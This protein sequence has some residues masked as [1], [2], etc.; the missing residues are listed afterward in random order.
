MAHSYT[1]GLKV[2][3]N[4]KILKE[5]RL[6]LK[7]SVDTSVGD[8]VAPGDTIAKTDLPGNVQMVNIANQLN[9]DA[10][11]VETVMIAKEGSKVS[12]NDLIAQTNGIFG[13]FKSSVNSPVDGTIESVSNITGQVVI[14]EAP[15][16]VEVDA[17]IRGVVDE[18]ITEEGVVIKSYGSF[19]QG[20]FGIGGESR[21]EIKMLSENRTSEISV[22]MIKPEHEGLIIVGGSF[23]SLEAYKK[24]LE[25]KV[26]GV[27]VGGFNYYDLEE[28]LGYTLGV[29]ITGS[30]ELIT[31]LIVT[32][33]YGKI[34]M[35]QQTFDLLRENSGRLAS[36][37]GATQIRAGVIRPEIIIP[38]DASSQ[39]DSDENSKK[40]SGMTEG[41]L[42]RVIRSPNFGKIGSVKELPSELRKMESETMVRVAII[43]IDGELI[44][45]PRSNLEVVETD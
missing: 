42:V 15:I 34:Q 17:Y 19:V 29:A 13:Y 25:C 8:T 33:G 24:A 21:G 41:S 37:N 27:V 26:A 43:D 45:I 9:V 35:G 6:P 32:E 14:R 44:E 1:P 40:M 12:K 18:V 30:E 16:P 2:L 11:D 36:I 31:S 28:I 7:G 39:K 4:T 3:K 5:R 38:S 20:I 22:D 23:I 10:S